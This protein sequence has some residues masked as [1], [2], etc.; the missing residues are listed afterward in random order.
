M[1]LLALPVRLI[2]GL[3]ALLGVVL[4]P[5]LGRLAWSAP[6]WMTATGAL[7]RR[8]PGR[9]GGGLL[10]VL[11]LGAAAW[12]GWQW[13][14]H[15]PRP[16]EPVHLHL[17]AELAPTRYSVDAD[18]KMQ[19]AVQPL[20]VTF[21]GS[22][23]PIEQVGK[24]AGDGIT[25]DPQ[26]PGAW[27][28]ADDWHLRFVPAQDWPVGARIEVR[29]D[30]AR[31]FA[32]HVIVDEDRFTASVRAF[33]SRFDGGEFYQDPQ[34]PAGKKVILPVT[35]N[36]PVDPATFEKR[37]KLEMVGNDGKPSSAPL[38]FSVT[39]DALKMRAWIHSQPLELSKDAQRLQATL[40][41]GVA[42]TRGGEATQD[43]LVTRVEVPRLYSLQVSGLSATLVDNPNG[44]PDQVVIANLSNTVRGE[45]L[46]RQIKAWVLPARNPDD[47]GGA[48]DG[49]YEWEVGQVTEAVLRQSRPLPLDL[50]PTEEDYA[51][52]QSFKY[53]AE[54]GQRIYVRVPAG[55]AAFGGYK[56]AT[57]YTVALT[58]PELP[59]L[60]RF[61]SD[62]S[63]LS[64]SGSKRV[65][66]ASRNV[67]GLR[68]EIGR[69]V[70][71]QLQ[72]LV[73]FNGGSYKRPD[74]SDF[75]EDLM[76]ERFAQTREIAAD[77]QREAHYEGIDLSRYLKPGKHGVFL[78]HL[79]VY[80]AE[81]AR[82]AA[83]RARHAAAEAAAT[84]TEP[85][86]MRDDMQDEDSD[87][88]EQG[89]DETPDPQDTRMV[90]VTDLGLVVKRALDQSQDVFVQ[91]IQTGQPVDG[92]QVSVQAANGQT[93]FTAQSVDGM[94]HFPSFKGLEREKTPV[95]YVVQKDD[96][97]SFLPIRQG[98][99]TLDYSR[100]D[101]G[102]DDNATSAGL[103]SAY[104]FSD[105]GIYRPGDVFHIGLIVRAAE[106][107][108]GSAGVPLQA[109]IVDPRGVTV[110]AQP[111]A[112]DASGFGE[113]SYTPAETAPTGAWSVNLYI[114][115][116]GES[117]KQIGTTT[118]Q[119]KDFQPDSMKVKATLSQQATEGWVK[120]G[121]LQAM[122]D[123]QNLFG[124]PAAHRR[125]EGKL[126]LRP[127]WPAFARWPGYA[128]YDTRRASE[129]YEEAL[130]DATTDEQGHAAFDLK[131]GRYADATYQLYFLAQAHE[132]AGGRSVAA[133]V[134]A[135]VSNNDWLVGYKADDDLD[136]IRLGASRKVRLVAIDPGAQAMALSGLTARRVE[137]RYVSV[138]TRE[139]SGAYRYVSKLKETTLDEQPLAIPA[140]GMDYTLRTDKPGSYALV[141]RREDG[142][143]VNR[144][145][146]S[147]AGEGNV[148]RSLDRNAELQITLD[149]TRYTPG[150]P[151]EIAVRAPYA[152]SGLITIERDKVYAHAWFHADTTS[153]VQHITLP[154]DFEGNG[155]V[156]VQYIRD[157]A[158]D[159]VFM[160]PLSYGVAPFSVSTENRQ[161]Q[162]SLAA[163]EQAKPGQPLTFHMQSS[164]PAR[165]VLFA[166]DEGI[167]QVAHYKLGNPLQYFFR[168]RR[169][170]VR[171]S[172]I[173]DLIL[174][175]FEKLMSTAAA[176]GDG[177]DTVGRQLNPFK[178]KRSQPAVF[179]SGIVDVDG[180]KDITYTPPDDFNGRLRVMAVAVS[181]DRLGTAET[182]TTVRGDFVLSPNAPATLAPGD[183]T[184]ISVGVANNL[185]HLDGKQ[186]PVTVTL[187]TGPQLQVVGEPTRSLTLG[188]M[189]EGTVTFR[190]RATSQLGNADLSLRAAYGS[191]SA[192]QSVSLSVRPAAPYRSQLDLGRVNAGDKRDLAGLRAMYDQ[193]AVCSAAMSTV[194]SV[195]NHALDDYL[196][197]YDYQDSTSLVSKAMPRLLQS[198]WP[199]VPVYS[200][201]PRTLSAKMAGDNR[202][203]LARVIDTLHARQNT[204]GGIGQWRAT[205]DA[206]PFA[207]VY[208][209]HFLLEARDRGIK[210]PQDMLDAGQAYLRDLA[211]SEPADDSLW[212]VRTRAY[213]VYLLTRQGI[214]TTNLLAMVQQTL[215]EIRPEDWQSDPAAAWL[216]AAYHL[217]K[218]DREAERLIS[219]P[220]KVLE[221]TD[222]K[223]AGRYSS[224]VLA[225]DASV[226]YLLAQYFPERAQALR[227]QALENIAKGLSGNGFTAVSAAVSELAL[228]TYAAGSAAA[229]E[230]L[231]IAAGSGKDDPVSIVSSRQEQVLAHDWSP[232][233]TRLRFINDSD[234]PAWF[235]VIQSGYDRVAEAA[236]VKDGI[237]IVRDYT[238]T[239]GKPLGKI[240]AGQ[241]IDVH[242]KIRSTAEQAVGS[243]AIVDL[244]PGGFDP[245]L[246]QP[247][248]GDD[249]DE[250][251]DGD[252]DGDNESDGDGAQAPAWRSPIGLNTSTWSPEYAEI[253]EDRIVLHGTATPDV[254]E[255]VYRIKASNTGT[256]NVPPA[257]AES[258]NDRRIQARAP[259]S[260][261]LTVEAAH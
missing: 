32:P 50:V 18:G 239:D 52:V 76:V 90:V 93:L 235:A 233:A 232:A 258:M 112:L 14:Q 120:P 176:G 182:G 30:K 189:R 206:D 249:A 178:R 179:W 170:Q 240:V 139:P 97:L 167:L 26:L 161:L 213:A 157:P 218:Q 259:G 204:Q 246:R 42:S 122:V 79:S 229:L 227:P 186:V 223:D 108:H 68:L 10:T 244:L 147:V 99:R 209:L 45:D 43:E 219:G 159:E 83:A 146:Y 241:E 197:H 152:G 261:K 210:V 82:K 9:V 80:D 173:L 40:A 228:D 150:Q 69:V 256:F 27:T 46:R 78:L 175:D 260:G 222:D 55:L 81:K 47:P 103:L 217:Q 126:T 247:P 201:A 136:Y 110:K 205:P 15:R 199:V 4:R 245:V 230:R 41:R 172:Q 124:T 143:E 184:D 1:K 144:I 121:Q 109:E 142:T 94:A 191:A 166:V 158:S 11:A 220:Q 251:Q 20:I 49:P 54:P 19:V 22:A 102:G 125:V 160:S 87:D 39:Y 61:M 255:F 236:P 188:E 8:H 177:D 104:L 56:L 77:A 253:R 75:H 192:R 63:L 130:E 140:A 137:R 224:D 145:G 95:M 73:N 151:I 134:Q 62:G 168:K 117:V 131:L 2:L 64:L 24:P 7:V 21:S 3:F 36:Y 128:F 155:Y 115:H 113:L 29:F 181:P 53:H 211:A 190:V 58:V 203:A 118:V 164:A 207:S 252:G 91:S 72:N 141:I 70:P 119:V 187:S 106:W 127:A 154:A 12:G 129:G 162:L 196:A 148:S 135:L 74:L 31:V 84:Q 100:F 71:Q 88:E 37:I 96:D 38:K 208:T 183:E 221:R 98:D 60:L 133:A 153:S 212:A 237:E 171:T 234:R 216:A 107:S 89:G 105:R 34:D 174:P 195:L 257:Y 226:L 165:V 242:I 66:I 92:A 23:A 238:G 65:S 16:P 57:P 114:A 156:N 194:P 86:E 163:P 243:V 33:A 13:W 111:L 116:N 185:T 248:S 214:V 51:A 28:W 215:A 250:E 67:P 149:K 25:M 6:P 169:L 35:F 85:D 44:E 193:Y 123:A 17:R 200:G 48:E 5:V 59:K 198:R 231:D 138:L 180:R 202:Q 101:I 132:A 254:R 225:S